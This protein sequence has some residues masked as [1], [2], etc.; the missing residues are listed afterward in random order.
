MATECRETK[1]R[2]I[3]R[4]KIARIEVAALFAFLI[5]IGLVIGL[6]IGKV[7]AKPKVEIQK[8]TIVETVEVPAYQQD[9]LPADYEVYY[10]DVPLSHNLQKYIYEICADEE[11][12]VTLIMAMI[13]HESQFNPEVVSDTNDYGLMQLNICVHEDLEANYRTADLLNP[14]QNVFCGVK[15]ISG[16]YAKYGDCAKALMAYNM[17]EYGAK[18]AWANGIDSSN[19][20]R[21]IM[22]LYREYEEELRNAT[23]ANNE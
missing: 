1:K 9:K 23:N 6:I 4:L 5:I 3:S 16:Y 13:E 18:K 22:N 19:Y 10:F 17:G 7:T 12:P 2:R 11:I 21:A 14:Y 20:S 15:V 8:E